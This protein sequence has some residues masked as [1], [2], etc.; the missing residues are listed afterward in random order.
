MGHIKS[1]HFMLTKNKSST[2]CIT[3]PLCWEFTD[4]Q[5]IAFMSLQVDITPSYQKYY[6]I[7]LLL[8]SIR[9]KMIHY[10]RIS[11]IWQSSI[12]S[13]IFALFY[14]WLQELSDSNS[15]ITVWLARWIWLRWLPSLPMQASTGDIKA[16]GELSP[17]L[18]N[19][20]GRELG[21][22]TA[23]NYNLYWQWMKD[24]TFRCNPIW[25][26]DAYK[27]QLI[28]LLLVQTMACRLIGAKPLS[29]LMM[30]YN[31]SG[32]WQHISIKCEWNKHIFIHFIA[33]ENF[34][35]IMSP[36]CLGLNGLNTLI[37]KQCKRT[38]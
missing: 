3:S 4:N 19:L 8:V 11:P 35:G 17:V 28:M 23:K 31:Q 20:K 34:V 25:P 1:P 26:S 18:F 16:S 37:L 29:Q 24:G 15:D 2:I 21:C 14:R 7:E 30:V 6:S 38:Q 10:K 36:F 27:H 5:C 32:P 33:F 22:E 13:F 12:S 9:P